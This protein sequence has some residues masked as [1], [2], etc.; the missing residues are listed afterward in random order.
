MVKRTYSVVILRLL[1]VAAALSLSSATARGHVTLDNPV[2][3][4]VLE[5]GSVFTIEWRILVAHTLQDW[6]LWYSTTGPA[7][8]WIPIAMNLPPGDPSAGSVHTYDWRVPFAPS[9]QIRIRVRM[10]N[11]GRD[12]EYITDS[13]LTIQFVPGPVPAASEWGVVVM[14]LL[15]ATAVTMMFCRKRSAWE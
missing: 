4:E 14:A 9:D 3:G 6:D 1:L 8:P 5:V 10:N 2:G 11:V 13:D 12:Y 7:G 15:I